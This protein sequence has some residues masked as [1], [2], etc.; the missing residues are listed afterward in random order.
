MVHGFNL[1]FDSFPHQ[2][3]YPGQILKGRTET[4]IASTL[5]SELLDK[6]VI[7]E[8]K[9][10]KS[11][12]VS[13]PKTYWR[14]QTHSKP[15]ALENSRYVPSLS[16]G[17]L[18][19]CAA[20]NNKGLF[21][22]SLGLA[23]AYYIV[24]IHPTHSKYLQFSFQGK[25]YRFTYLANGISSA[26]RTFTKLMKIPLSYLR[27]R[28]G[29]LITSYLDDLL[30][31]ADSPVQLLEAVNKAYNLLT[32]L[33]FSISLTKSSLVPTHKIQFLG[34]ILDSEAMTITLP[35]DKAAAI[36]GNIQS[37]L[38]H[39]TVSIRHFATLVGQ[40][41]ATLPASRYGRVFLKY[42][43]MAKTRALC[44]AD[45]DYDRPIHLHSEVIEELQ[46][47]LHDIDHLYHSMY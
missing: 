28:F 6:G 16:D 35:P 40:L 27:R 29:F 15:K 44:S 45:F 10:D 47:W 34:F 42:S 22:V 7:Q 23:D 12:Y 19:L 18:G 14:S 31:M 36:R 1:D 43:E 39:H 41:T 11:G 17:T 33:G 9:F 4:I 30:I 2:S 24:I 25:H 37:C 21:F 20:T 38:H 46:W 5:P 13:L 8:T 26:P 3:I 32:S